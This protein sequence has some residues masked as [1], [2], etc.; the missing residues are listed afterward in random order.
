VGA[1]FSQYSKVIL[2]EKKN[3]NTLWIVRIYWIVNAA[4]GIAFVTAFR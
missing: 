4:F 3:I 1:M 2:E